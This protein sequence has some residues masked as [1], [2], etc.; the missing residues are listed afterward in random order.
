M[1]TLKDKV[2]LVT[3]AN[4][5]IGK[6]LVKESLNK[7]AKK[8]YATCRDLSKMPKFEDTRVV[9]LELDVTNDYQIEQVLKQASDTE[10]LINNA[11]VL[12][13]GSILKGEIADIKKDM[14]VNYYGTLGMM[15]SFSSVLES[16]SPSRMINITSIVAYSP[17]PSIAGYS[18][19][20]AALLSA[21][22]S[23]RIELA[24]K[25][26]TVHAVNPGAIDT[27]MNKG[28]DWDMPSPDNV[29]KVILDKVENEELDIIP[30]DIGLG[31]FKAWKEDPKKLAE[32]FHNIYHAE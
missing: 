4:R 17:L 9:I 31:M 22:Y 14:N 12:S 25:G 32:I 2:I 7:G 6:S 26:V 3:G 24:K 30:E 21:T 1:Q 16:N 11:G 27:D 29:A 18:A 23:V 10:V 13:A 5:G 19:S 28:S 15:K 20:K 8:V